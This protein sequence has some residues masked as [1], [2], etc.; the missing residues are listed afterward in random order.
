MISKNLNPS[1]WIG[2]VRSLCI[3]SLG[4]AFALYSSEEYL[5]K[6]SSSASSSPAPAARSSSSNA[7]TNPLG[8][9]IAEYSSPAD[10]ANLS[11]A[12][13]VDL[14]F[15]DRI[16]EIAFQQ[17][18]VGSIVNDQPIPNEI[19]ERL[20]RI[21]SA[22]K[23]VIVSAIV[24]KI[25]NQSQGIFRFVNPFPAFLE[26]YF[27]QV[28]TDEL[29]GLSKESSVHPTAILHMKTCGTYWVSRDKKDDVN[30]LVVCFA[31]SYIT[32]NDALNLPAAA[33][34]NHVIATE[35]QINNRTNCATIK[36]FFQKHPECELIA[37]FGSKDK[38]K[39]FEYFDCE[40]NFI[41]IRKLSVVGRNLRAIGNGFCFDY[42]NL[43]SI[44]IPN[45][46]QSIEGGFCRG[47]KNLPSLTLPD[48]VRE[49]GESF[50]SYTNL[51]SLKLSNNLVCFGDWFCHRCNSLPTVSF[52][53]TLRQVGFAPL[54]N[55]DK[56]TS[57]VVPRKFLNEFL[58][59]FVVVEEFSP[60]S[61][62]SISRL[63][64]SSSSSS[65]NGLVMARKI[66]TASLNV[67]Q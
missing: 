10:N 43:I 19:Y 55:C 47:C 21:N 6:S 9:T 53:Y 56:L 24:A 62:S 5:T 26:R 61:S 3:I 28:R 29:A 54:E 39:A 33:V 14:P 40:E 22:Q 42:V 34:P 31:L 59:K 4:G 27:R 38:A 58:I 25:L 44:L 48:S 45:T 50:C 20:N 16:D 63:A 13:V 1:V 64:S 37:D 8:S 7:V 2:V 36:S 15:G 17:S 49:I 67:N 66:N 30:A 65:A 41:Y 35:N 11:R 60:Q 51:I 52:P 23:E 18:I 32:L 57:I 12:N 46:V